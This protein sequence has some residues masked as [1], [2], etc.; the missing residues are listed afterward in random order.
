AVDGF[1]VAGKTGTAQ[2][3]NPETGGYAGG[4]YNTT[5]VGFAPADD[6]KYVIAVDLERPNSDAEGG[7]VAAP[8]FADLMRYA[9]I[10]SGA[11]PSGTE[12]PDFQ[13]TGP[14]DDDAPTD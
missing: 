9:L 2:R 4:G 5:F 6:P 1:R 8:V 7:Q 3:A 10:S 14:A 11:V 12:R 13:L